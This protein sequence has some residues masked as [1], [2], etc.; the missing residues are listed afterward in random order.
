MDV[1]DVSYPNMFEI[2]FLYFYFSQLSKSNLKETDNP[3]K[4]NISAT[5]IEAGVTIHNHLFAREQLASMV[6]LV[7]ETASTHV[8]TPK[9]V[10]LISLQR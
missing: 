3:A 5:I 10:I 2:L 8:Q 1:L 9:W 6:H 4:H 7:S